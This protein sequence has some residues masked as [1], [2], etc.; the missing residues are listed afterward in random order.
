MLRLRDFCGKS[1]DEVNTLIA[2]R[3]GSVLQDLPDMTEAIRTGPDTEEGLVAR[4]GV[5]DPEIARMTGDVVRVVRQHLDMF[6]LAR[7]YICNECI[8][9]FFKCLAEDDANSSTDLRS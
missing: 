6:A 2:G 5:D 8:A 7:G 1:R 4:F 3:F 9:F